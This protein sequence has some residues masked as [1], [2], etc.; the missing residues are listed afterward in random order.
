MQHL[1]GTIALKARRNP[2]TERPLRRQNRK[3][4]QRGIARN[5]RLQIRLGNHVVIQRTIARDQRK[6]SGVTG[7][8]IEINGAE[9][10]DKDTVLARTHKKRHIFI[11][12]LAESATTI[13]IPGND[14]LTALIKV[15]ELLAEAE[16]VLVRLGRKGIVEGHAPAVNAAHPEGQ[17][18]QLHAHIGELAVV[19]HQQ[20]APISPQKAHPKGPEGNLD[21]QRGTAQRQALL[22]LE[23]QDFAVVRRQ[24]ARQAHA[25][26]VPLFILQQHARYEGYRR[27]LAA[28]GLPF[29]E[30]L[31]GDGD[32]TPASGYFWTSRFLDLP[33]P[34]TALFSSNDTMVAGVM[35]AVQERGLKVPDDLAVVG[36][37]DLPQTTMIYPELT[38]IRQPCVEMGACAA[39]MLIRQLEEHTQEPAH[40]IFSTTLIIRDSCGMKKRAAGQADG[41]R[42]T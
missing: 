4:H 32:W 1:P 6:R 26:R 10:I 39:E 22:L 3:A 13:A 33:E 17:N 14:A 24:I 21:T 25:R 41:H 2:G 18:G 11:S 16:K 42:S 29:D 28:A 7:H 35:R 38:T 23:N 40:I 12:A 27:A 19:L 34:P 20:G 8:H 9:T 5:D 37:D 36:F 15:G 30:A 31:V